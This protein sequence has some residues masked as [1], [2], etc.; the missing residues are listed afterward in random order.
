MTE[1]LRR[2]NQVSSLKQ[3]LLDRVRSLRDEGNSMNPGLE[4][5]TAL[6]RAQTAARMNGSARSTD[7][8]N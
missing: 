7:R 3:R 1:K 4:R 5:E 6:K 8:L 2:Y